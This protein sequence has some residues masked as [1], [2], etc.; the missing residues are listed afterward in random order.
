MAAFGAYGK[1]LRGR[2]EHLY[3]GLLLALAARDEQS[4]N[5][6]SESAGPPRTTTETLVPWRVQMFPIRL[7]H[8]FGN[9][10][11]TA[12]LPRENAPSA[13]R[14]TT[15]GSGREKAPLVP[16]D[17]SDGGALTEA[18]GLDALL[19]VFL[20]KANGESEFTPQ[21]EVLSDV[22]VAPVAAHAP[23]L[24]PLYVVPPADPDVKVSPPDDEPAPSAPAASLSHEE[25]S[26]S[27]LDNLNK[28]LKNLQSGSPGIEAS[29]L[30]S[31]DGL[32]IASAL[33]QDL[34]ETRVGGMSATLL[35]LGTRAATELRRGD[36]RETIVRGDSG[37]AVMINAGRG[38]MLLVLAQETTP[39]GL[40][41]FDMREALKSIR[42]IL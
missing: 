27:R 18:T 15:P 1:T 11:D 28:V 3:R 29:A 39:L 32:M 16:V 22:V 20:P 14:D 2:D 24:R 36:V 23:V 25:P 34:D 17:L 10:P 8:R 42:N 5:A 40:I 19:R 37:C 41:F 33:P 31:E 21:I 12:G 9:P 7:I 4:L 13:R 26:M 6:A 30:I 38:A 35:N